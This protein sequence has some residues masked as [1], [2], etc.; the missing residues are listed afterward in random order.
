MGPGFDAPASTEGSLFE[1]PSADETEVGGGGGSISVTVGDEGLETGSGRD[2][3]GSSAE[4][5]SMA[6]CLVDGGDVRSV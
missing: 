5:V 2:T 6:M 3:I 1:L 4:E